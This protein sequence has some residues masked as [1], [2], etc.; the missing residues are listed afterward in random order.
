[1]LS[2]T[3]KGTNPIPFPF[4][5]SNT[6][7][8]EGSSEIS[9]FASSLSQTVELE[10]LFNVSKTFSLTRSEIATQ[11]RRPWFK[12][13]G[14]SPYLLTLIIDPYR[15][16][17]FFFGKECWPSS[18]TEYFPLYI[19]H[20]VYSFAFLD[21]FSN[22][23]LHHPQNVLVL[24]NVSTESQPVIVQGEN[25]PQN[26]L[27]EKEALLTV[28][29]SR[30]MHINMEACQTAVL[31]DPVCPLMETMPTSLIPLSS[32]N[33]NV[34]F[35]QPIPLITFMDVPLCDTKDAP[36]SQENVR[37]SDVQS[38][39]YVTAESFM[40]VSSDVVQENVP[41]CDRHAL[42]CAVC[43][44]EDDPLPKECVNSDLIQGHLILTKPSHQEYIPTKNNKNSRTLRKKTFVYSGPRRRARVCECPK[45]DQGAQH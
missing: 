19:V 31:D 17:K 25:M 30:G 8:A 38:E 15:I 27:S 2:N 9:W 34:P 20:S 5:L 7:E 4:V 6:E 1:M 11:K 29:L 42:Q 37:Q 21:I 3:L 35:L 12:I 24:S 16:V 28:A 45:H 44:L 41:L 23:Y 18:T 14:R 39:T 26:N 22:L 10:D 13:G 40:P 33:E 43:V 36:S 32:V